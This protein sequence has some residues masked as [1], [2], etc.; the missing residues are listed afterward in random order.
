VC[1]DQVVVQYDDSI[2]FLEERS[3]ANIVSSSRHWSQT[4]KVEAMF[5]TVCHYSA[6]GMNKPIAKTINTSSPAAS[7]G[8]CKMKAIMNSIVRQTRAG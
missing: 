5:Y 1:E 4:F 3:F 8:I 2:P 7:G 6:D